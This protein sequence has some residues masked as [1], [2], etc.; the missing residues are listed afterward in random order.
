MKIL[1]I[2]LVG[3][4]LSI[5]ASAYPADA[6]KDAPTPGIPLRLLA[7]GEDDTITYALYHAP[8]KQKEVDLVLLIRNTGAKWI[9][10]E[11]IDASSFGLSDDKGNH[12]KIWRATGMK[13]IAYQNMVVVHIYVQGPASEEKD[14]TLELTPKPKAFVPIKFETKPFRFQ[15]MEDKKDSPTKPLTATE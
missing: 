2:L 10:T 15:K 13:G 6:Q 5:I 14:Y 7:A 9:D 12:L 1:H 8:S 4:C 3:A 11:G